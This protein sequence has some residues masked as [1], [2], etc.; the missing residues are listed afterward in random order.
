MLQLSTELFIFAT[1][2]VNNRQRHRGERLSFNP[3]VNL[4]NS[5]C[6]GAKSESCFPCSSIYPAYSVMESAH[7]YTCRCEPISFL[8]T[9]VFQ[10]LQ[11]IEWQVGSHSLCVSEKVQ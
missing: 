11:A 5:K 6:M 3:P 10:N 8:H 4:E 2:F 9:Q 1:L 7:I